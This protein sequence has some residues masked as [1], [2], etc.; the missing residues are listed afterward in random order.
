MNCKVF[1]WHGEDAGWVYAGIRD[2]DFDK[3]LTFSNWSWFIDDDRLA[4]SNL[5]D[6]K[7]SG[8]QWKIV[9]YPEP[10][11]KTLQYYLKLAQVEASTLESP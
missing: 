11:Q 4:T 9:W 5:D 10:D 6:K 2:W 3:H 8:T 7:Y 1:G